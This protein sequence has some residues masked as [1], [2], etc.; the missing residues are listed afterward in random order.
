MEEY[1]SQRV[2]MEMNDLYEKF[3]KK[4]LLIFQ[5]TSHICAYLLEDAD[6]DD[7]EDD[8]VFPFL[9]LCKCYYANVLKFFLHIGN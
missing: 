1:F 2:L 9:H 4:P 8:T 6:D 3:F 5:I 7:A